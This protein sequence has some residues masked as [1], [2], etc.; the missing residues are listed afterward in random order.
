MLPLIT[1][2]KG[3]WA[4]VLSHEVSHTSRRHQVI[5]YNRMV[6]NQ[7]MIEY[8]RRRSDAG[9][10]SATWALL[11]FHIAAPIAL[12]K[13]ERDQ[14]HEA[15]VQGM[16]LMAHAGY[17]PD[18]V[19]A[20]H[21][22]LL[23]RGGEQSK[24]AA[25]F[26]DHPR[27]ET[28]DQRS[29][30]AYLDALAEFNRVWPDAGASPGG[31]PPLVAFVG[32]PVAKDDKITE[33]ADISIPLYCR[34]AFE[35][36]DVILRFEKDNRPV[37]TA[38]A[39]LADKEGNLAFR[40]TVDCLDK[41]E[42]VPVIIPLPA[43]A[44]SDHDRSIRAKVFIASEN[45]VIDQSQFFNVHFPKSKRQKID[46]ISH[47]QRSAQPVAAP[48]ATT[49]TAAEAKP[50]NSGGGMG[51]TATSKA[52]EGHGRVYG[53]TTAAVLAQPDSDVSVTLLGLTT[54]TLANMGAEIREVRPGSVAELAYLRIGDVINAVDGRSV[55]TAMELTAALSN[56]A[57][58]SKIRVG[59][60][61]STGLGY[62]PKEVIVTPAQ[63]R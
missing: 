37:Q 39:Q 57:P 13:L 52:T 8:Y 35:P 20:L 29:D 25:F 28:R 21:H 17:H 49:S 14:E 53:N 24:F 54:A 30:R 40:E 48:A 63:N 32:H 51:F 15:D 1:D 9:D 45:T 12:K 44:V 46:M 10:K 56:R 26:S 11:A 58:G 34:N 5:T 47:S 19:F 42:T 18:N 36:V 7:R 6:F 4:A 61:L 43:A 38:D 55:K 31:R 2:N 60:L 33:T 22:L 23:L 41:N 59:Y 62:F 16:L 27:W 3:L 50:T